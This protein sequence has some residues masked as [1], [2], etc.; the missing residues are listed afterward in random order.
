[1]D[2]RDG[3]ASDYRM[4]EPAFNFYSIALEDTTPWR[5]GFE[6][7]ESV[8]FEKNDIEAVTRLSLKYILDW[9][10]DQVPRIRDALNE[11]RKNEGTTTIL[12]RARLPL[13]GPGNHEAISILIPVVELAIEELKA[14]ATTR[15][16]SFTNRSTPLQ[17]G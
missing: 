8:R 2:A 12:L 5:T 13:R 16:E 6:R 1:M 9:I 4:N 15:F 10:D 3:S 7:A 11:M 14:T 17:S